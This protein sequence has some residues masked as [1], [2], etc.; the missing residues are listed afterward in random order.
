M[1]WSAKYHSLADFGT[2]PLS[3]CVGTKTGILFILSAFRLWVIYDLLTHSYL[4]HKIS[5]SPFMNNYGQAQKHAAF[6]HS[7]KYGSFDRSEIAFC[8]E[9]IS[10]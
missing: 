1:V 7:I 3:K 5:A 6:V 9:N 4:I 8:P 2:Y 10:P